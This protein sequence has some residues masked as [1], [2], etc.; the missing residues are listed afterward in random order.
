MAELKKIVPK[1]WASSTRDTHTV[2]QT[3]DAT[4]GQNALDGV[5]HC[6]GDLPP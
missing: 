1:C 5:R 2:L 4:T 3:V 6:F